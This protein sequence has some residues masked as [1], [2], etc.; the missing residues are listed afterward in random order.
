MWSGFKKRGKKGKPGRLKTV[1]ST[2]PDKH[3]DEQRNTEVPRTT[4]L[5]AL[6]ADS[7]LHST[8]TLDQRVLFER[9]EVTL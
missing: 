2:T 4:L 7:K 9:L 8:H 3:G 5:S 6:G 1:L